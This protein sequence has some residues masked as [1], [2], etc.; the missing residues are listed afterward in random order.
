MLC[1][2]DRHIQHAL[3]S[4]LYDIQPSESGSVNFP[5]P[6]CIL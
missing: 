6:G 1:G 3:E 2:Y 4:F 5:L